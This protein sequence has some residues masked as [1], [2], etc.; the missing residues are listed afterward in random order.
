M[1]PPVCFSGFNKE[2]RISRQAGKFTTT[3]T[4]VWSMDYYE[5]LQKQIIKIFIPYTAYETIRRQLKALGITHDTIYVEDDEKDK[6]AKAIAEET[7][8]RFFDLFSS[9]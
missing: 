9:R 8:K 4:L 6:I 5:V 2:K 7:K 1:V 3:G